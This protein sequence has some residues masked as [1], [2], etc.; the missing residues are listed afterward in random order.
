[1][2]KF[3]KILSGKAGT[4]I[5][6]FVNMNAE[7]VMPQLISSAWKV[8]VASCTLWAPVTSTSRSPIWLENPDLDDAIGPH[9]LPVQ[10]H[11]AV[12]L[13]V[14]PEWTGLSKNHCRGHWGLYW[15]RHCMEVVGKAFQFDS[16][17]PGEQ[18][19][20]DPP[21]PSHQSRGCKPVQLT[22]DPGRE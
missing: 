7:N 15:W 11:L 17:S 19:D 14:G 1:M 12:G 2:P 6:F 10:Q 18:E 20:L 16:F 21:D 4:K 13:V 5:F 9:W 3:L 8:A 22:F